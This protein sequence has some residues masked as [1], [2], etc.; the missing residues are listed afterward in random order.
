MTR[1]STGPPAADVTLMRRRN[2]RRAL[3]ADR[4][5]AAHG[6]DLLP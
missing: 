2:V 5:F 3:A 4:H 6:F 1:S